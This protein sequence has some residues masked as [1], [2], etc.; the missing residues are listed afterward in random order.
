MAKTDYVVLSYI[1]DRSIGWGKPF[2]TASAENVLNGTEMY[3][4]VGVSRT[5]YY[6]SLKRLEELGAIYRRS[7]RDRTLIWPTVDWCIDDF[8]PEDPQS[9]D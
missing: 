2:F 5:A 8:K 1:I 6:G 3:S 7:L 4:G 9:D